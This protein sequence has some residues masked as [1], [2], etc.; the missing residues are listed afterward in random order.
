MGIVLLIF[1]NM[2]VMAVYHYMEPT[3]VTDVLDML[4]IVFIFIFT[5]EAAVKII[6]LRF[7]YFR[8]VW[9]L[10]DFFV[11]FS[12]L[13]GKWCNLLFSLFR[14]CKPFFFFLHSVNIIVFL[15]CFFQHSNPFLAFIKS[16]DG[17]VL[18]FL[19]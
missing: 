2:I 12:S 8:Q 7:Y 11:V 9:N 18:I 1:L 3:S 5:S 15:K 19:F 17:Q 14:V 4:N 16:F 10:F 6:G 13:L